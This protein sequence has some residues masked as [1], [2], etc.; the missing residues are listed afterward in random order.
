MPDFSVRL[1]ELNDRANTQLEQIFQKDVREYLQ[2]E[3]VAYFPDYTPDRGSENV[4]V[5]NFQL[6]ANMERGMI[7]WHSRDRLLPESIRPQVVKAIVAVETDFRP[8]NNANEQRQRF[9]KQAAFK[10]LDKSKILDQSVFR[11]L[12]D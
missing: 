5:D 10:R 9:V 4:K 11:L 6:P 8:P 7:L 12:W 1:I 3:S 2:L